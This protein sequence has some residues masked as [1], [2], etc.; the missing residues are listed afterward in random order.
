VPVLSG[1]SA[2][3][4]NFLHE[5]NKCCS[6]G[7]AGV[8][9]QHV[10]ASGASSI[11]PGHVRSLSFPLQPWTSHCVNSAAQHSSNQWPARVFYECHRARD[12]WGCVQSTDIKHRSVLLDL[13]VVP[14]VK[15]A[16]FKL[17]V[18]TNREA[19]QMADLFA[20][21]L[22]Q[23]MCAILSIGSRSYTI[24]CKEGGSAASSSCQGH[25]LRLSRHA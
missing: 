1:G 14:P 6:A 18:A 23:V 2:S 9:L 15:T 17:T 13:Q 24:I 19:V 3:K 7:P 22:M 25:Q 21:M 8:L 10:S 4:D 20:D 12:C 11:A 16:D 5:L